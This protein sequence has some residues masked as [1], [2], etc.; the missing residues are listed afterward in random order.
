MRM[1]RHRPATATIHA[2]PVLA[3]RR[4]GRTKPGDNMTEP[5]WLPGFFTGK[6][7][8]VVNLDD[9]MIFHS[10]PVVWSVCGVPVLADP[11]EPVTGIPCAQCETQTVAFP[12]INQGAP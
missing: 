11:R 8:A 6:I 12:S 1:P 7:H 4:A 2:W 5:A 9:R 3:P 10:W